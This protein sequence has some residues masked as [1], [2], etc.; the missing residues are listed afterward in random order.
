M[1]EA[2]TEALDD[3][4]EYCLGQLG[5]HP[6]RFYLAACHW[7]GDLDYM[8]S[9][10]ESAGYAVSVQYSGAGAILYELTAQ[11]AV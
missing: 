5:G 3:S 6:E 9:Y 8:L 1:G 11:G 7:S 2:G 4:I 10:F